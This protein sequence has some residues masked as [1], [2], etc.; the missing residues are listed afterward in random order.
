MRTAIKHL[1]LGTLTTTIIS[2]FSGCATSLRQAP[3]IDISKAP[4]GTYALFAFTIEG[5]SSAEQPRCKVIINQKGTKQVHTYAFPQGEWGLM[6]LPAGTYSYDHIDCGFGRRYLATNPFGKKQNEFAIL[7]SKINYLGHTTLSF[8]SKDDLKLR[9]DQKDHLE[10]IQ[11][12]FNKLPANSW[13]ATNTISAYTQRSIRPDMMGFALA[14]SYSLKSRAH[15]DEQEKLKALLA[16]VQSRIGKCAETEAITNPLKI[17]AFQT[18]YTLK[19]G[20]FVEQEKR[21]SHVYSKAFVACV[22][23]SMSSITHSADYQVSFDMA[24]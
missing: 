24:L 19:N 17:G 6:A 12:L 1:A 9:Y 5:I 10:K 4:V 22:K 16:T 20:K 23:K 7:P 18:I 8:D 2:T 13:A 3:S 11:N 15:K 14:R 21:E